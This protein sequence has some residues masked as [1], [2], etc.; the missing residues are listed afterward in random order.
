MKIVEISIRVLMDGEPETNTPSYFHSDNKD[1]DN[2]LLP[3]IDISKLEVILKNR[4]LEYL[5]EAKFKL[6]KGLARIQSQLDEY[7]D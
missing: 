1:A 3:V 2:Y 4:N 7:N 6:E 5:K